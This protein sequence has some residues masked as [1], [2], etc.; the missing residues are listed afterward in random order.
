MVTLGCGKTINAA[1]VAATEGEGER[2]SDADVAAASEALL[3]DCGFIHIEYIA[4]TWIET[5]WDR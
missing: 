3:V 5:V 4:G 1:A 2:A